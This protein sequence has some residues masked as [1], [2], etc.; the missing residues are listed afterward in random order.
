[1]TTDPLRWFLTRSLA[2]TALAFGLLAL[3]GSAA[4]L[5][6]AGAAWMLADAVLLVA[7]AIL[8][9]GGLVWLRDAHARSAVVRAW[10]TL[11]AA[12][13]L[14]LGILVELD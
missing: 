6:D 10:V 3:L 9:A 14:L 4:W 2:A 11:G 5:R 1:M 12:L 7:A 8:L 13:L